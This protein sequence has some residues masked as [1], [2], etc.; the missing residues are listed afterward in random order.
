MAWTM[1][2]LSV[3]GYNRPYLQASRGALS[4]LLQVFTSPAKTTDPPASVLEKGKDSRRLGNA[5]STVE[6][7]G[8]A[9]IKN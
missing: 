5:M 6:P 2:L 1:R 3:K 4:R 9:R 8:D 7:D